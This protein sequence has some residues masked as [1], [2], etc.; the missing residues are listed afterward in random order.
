M[1]I[2]K[3]QCQSQISNNYLSSQNEFSHKS[4][5]S[6]SS[7]P[8]QLESNNY[9]QNDEKINHPIMNKSSH[10][11]SPSLAP[12]TDHDDHSLGTQPHTLER[13]SSSTYSFFPQL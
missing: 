1:N 4:S 11:S 8:N 7:S 5:F 9:P 13:D 12:S 3:E 10:Q 6:N 2:N